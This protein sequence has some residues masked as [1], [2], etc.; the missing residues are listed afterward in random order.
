MPRLP[1][2][3]PVGAI[4]CLRMLLN[5]DLDVL[6]GAKKA[7][8]VLFYVLRD[9]CTDGDLS[10]PEALE[11]ARDIFSK[12]SRKLYK[13]KAVSESFDSND[14]ASPSSVK[15]DLTAP[16]DDVAFVRIIWVDTSGQHRCRVS[17]CSNLSTLTGSIFF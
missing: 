9:A 7:R 3:L 13:M 15:L 16:L 4:F 14:I 17:I 11:A 1:L 10:I 2:L 6:L 5:L 12:N 8:E